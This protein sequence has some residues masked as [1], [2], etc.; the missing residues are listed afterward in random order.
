MGAAALGEGWAQGEPRLPEVS[1]MVST[2]LLDDHEGDIPGDAAATT[3]GLITP[4]CRERPK[5]LRPAT[6]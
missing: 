1:V 2:M 5:T 4:R 6:R 3:A